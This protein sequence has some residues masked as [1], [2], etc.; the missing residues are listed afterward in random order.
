MKFS[1]NP[2]GKILYGVRQYNEVSLSIIKINIYT[3]FSKITLPD[4][5]SIV[6]KKKKKLASYI[7]VALMVKS[8]LMI[9]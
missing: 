8:K 6:K 4:L 1:K 2:L 5:L 3:A 9:T 7:I